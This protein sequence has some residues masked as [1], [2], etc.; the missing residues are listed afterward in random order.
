LL[1]VLGGDGC[2]GDVNS[3]DDEVGPAGLGGQSHDLGQWHRP[4]R[5]YLGTFLDESAAGAFRYAVAGTQRAVGVATFQ[6]SAGQDRLG[7]G[8][9]GPPAG[10]DTPAIAGQGRGE[11]VHDGGW[12]GQGETVDDGA[13]SLRVLVLHTADV[14][15]ASSMRDLP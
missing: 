9:V 5:Q 15:E 2:D 12:R 11:V 14:P 8:V 1:G 6:P 10:T 4:P 7:G 3:V 13:G